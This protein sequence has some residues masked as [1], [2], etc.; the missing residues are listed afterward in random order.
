MR[1]AITDV[2]IAD[3]ALAKVRCAVLDDETRVY[4][5]KPEPPDTHPDRHRYHIP[6]VD[7]AYRILSACGLQE[8]ERIVFLDK[9][10]NERTGYSADFLADVLIYLRGATRKTGYKSQYVAEQKMLFEVSKILLR[11]FVEISGTIDMVDRYTGY[12]KVRDSKTL[13]KIFT[14]HLEGKVDE[15][16]VG[17]GILIHEFLLFSIHNMLRK[18]GE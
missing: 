15:F 8:Q 17:T 13:Q 4:L 10:G 18:E 3:I 6:F 2:C 9:K 11:M 12:D 1:K 16:D 14:K 5:S 7:I